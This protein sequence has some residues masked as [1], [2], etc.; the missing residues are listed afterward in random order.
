MLLIMIIRIL[1]AL[2][3]I[4]SQ[5]AFAGVYRWTD[6][7]GT[8]H[9]GDTP[10]PGAEKVEV[11]PPQV[12]ES[13]PVTAPVPKREPSRKTAFTYER[14]GIVK[15]EQGETL[16]DASGAVQVS[17]MVEPGLQ[18]GHQIRFYMDG[19]V[20]ENP[21]RSTSLTLSNVPRG[22]HTIKA[23]IVDAQGNKVAETAPVTF[24][25]RRP[26]VL[27]DGQNKKRQSA[28]GQGKNRQPAGNP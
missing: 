10:G 26:S 15:P 25:L 21:D 17:L 16:H 9:F 27:I 18:A 22:S 24:H 2:S 1:L 23:E 8:V 20:A 6:E 19:V 5:S 7:S 14:F 3:L 12:Y 4:V 11:P 28:D 13:P